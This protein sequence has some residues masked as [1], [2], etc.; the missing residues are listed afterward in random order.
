MTPWSVSAKLLM[1][2]FA[3]ASING[4]T[5]A[6]PASREYSVWQCR[7]TNSGEAIT[8]MLPGMAVWIQSLVHTMPGPGEENAPA[9]PRRYTELVA[10]DVWGGRADCRLTS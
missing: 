6:R 3:A 5:R 8:A 4:P 7:W 9:A 10:D 1:P 2:C